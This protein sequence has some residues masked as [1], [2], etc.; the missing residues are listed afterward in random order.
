MAVHK[1]HGTIFEG[2]V[3][4]LLVEEGHVD[5]LHVELVPGRRRRRKEECLDQNSGRR[6]R[7]EKKE[8]KEEKEEE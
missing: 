4:I 8:E 7:R 5:L 3:R 2:G 6:R 1:E